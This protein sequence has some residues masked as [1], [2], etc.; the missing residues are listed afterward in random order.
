MHVGVQHLLAKLQQ[1]GISTPIE[2]VPATLLGAV[3]LTPFEV[4]QVYQSIAASGFTV[5]LRAVTVV[6]TTS[7]ETLN[8]YPLRLMPLPQR[9]AVAVLNY[10]LTQVV[11]TGTA[12]ALPGLLGSRVTI[13]GK[14]GTTNERRDSWFV[15]YTRD[16]VAVTWVGQ[17]DNSPAG[18]TGGTAAMQLWAG[19]FRSLP[20]NPVDLDMPEGAYWMWVNP[21]QNL[22]SD[23]SCDGAVQLPFVAGSEPDMADRC[24]ER[25]GRDGKKSLWRKLFDD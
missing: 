16:L 13:A 2:A 19:L 23:E 25:L 14:T 8:R 7:G 11:E 9:P 4:A 10:A 22:L 15:G 17:D 18:V 3:E 21:D 6:Q 12:R 1:L 5:P 24:L 20:L